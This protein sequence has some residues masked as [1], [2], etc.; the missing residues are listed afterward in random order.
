LARVTA[1]GKML[2]RPAGDA[3]SRAAR[4]VAG[5]HE[6]TDCASGCYGRFRDRLC[7]D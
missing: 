4:S 2:E 5:R 7:D 1:F 6:G 3:K